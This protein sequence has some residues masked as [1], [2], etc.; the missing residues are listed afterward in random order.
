MTEGLR[1]AIMHRLKMKNTYNKKRTQE[2][3]NSYKMQ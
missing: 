2:G 3:L 1:K